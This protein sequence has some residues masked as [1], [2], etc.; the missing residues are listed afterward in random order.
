MMS[1]T[2][3]AWLRKYLQPLGAVIVVPVDEPRATKISTYVVDVV[4]TS[5]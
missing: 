1:R 5:H 3:D 4:E 2:Y